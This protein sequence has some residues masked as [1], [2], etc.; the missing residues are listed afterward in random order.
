MNEV[1]MA[2]VAAAINIDDHDDDVQQW[3]PS[4]SSVSCC[5]Q[6]QSKKKKIRLRNNN[7]S[8]HNCHKLHFTA[9]LK[10]TA[11]KIATMA[12]STSSLFFTPQTHLH[13]HTRA[14]MFIPLELN[15]IL[16]AHAYICT[17]QGKIFIVN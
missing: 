8:K 15:I 12:L 17:L 1:A 13:A 2:A 11:E 4:S 9:Q 7:N 10:I 3:L 16:N 14:R 6:Q 5:W